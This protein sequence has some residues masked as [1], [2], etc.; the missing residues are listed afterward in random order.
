MY[1]QGKNGHCTVYGQISL[2]LHMSD[3][4]TASMQRQCL[5]AKCN[6]STDETFASYVL[7]CEE[8]DANDLCRRDRKRET[9]ICCHLLIRVSGRL[10]CFDS[11]VK[12]GHV[13]FCGL[14]MSRIG[15]IFR[16]LTDFP[17]ACCTP[18]CYYQPYWLRKYHWSAR[19]N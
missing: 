9:A 5:I 19:R 8:Y 6:D 14:L 12:F 11:L 10:R 17:L 7:A 18:G 13:N 15:M 1:H 4:N 2:S 3:S 16:D